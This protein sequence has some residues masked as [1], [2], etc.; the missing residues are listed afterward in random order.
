MNKG[1]DLPPAD[2]TVAA[3]R[4]RMVMHQARVA[5]LAGGTVTFR[6]GG[7]EQ[8][9]WGVFGT[10]PQTPDT[11]A[12]LSPLRDSSVPARWCAQG[13]DLLKMREVLLTPLWESWEERM[14][15]FPEEHGRSWTLKVALGSKSITCHRWATR[16]HQDVPGGA[17]KGVFAHI[18]LRSCG[19]GV[20]G[21]KG[22]R[23][24]GHPDF[25]RHTSWAGR[26][27]L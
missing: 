21:R 14:A 13:H 27:G 18:H 19:Q 1:S 15:P 25:H 3:R 26:T 10:I 7:L 24:T 17:G 5:T 12:C 6:D 8:R 16:S 20:S 9:V 11:P 23:S 4:K 22:L 2:E